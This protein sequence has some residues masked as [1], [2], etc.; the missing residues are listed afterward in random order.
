MSGL[1]S[2]AGPGLDPRF[3]SGEGVSVFRQNGRVQISR[4]TRFRFGEFATAYAVLRDI[5][6]VFTGEDFEPVPNY[7]GLESGMRRSLVAAY[8]AGID[9]SDPAQLGRLIRVF[10]DAI[11]SWGR[12]DQGEFVQSAKEMIR[13]LQ[14]DGVPLDDA[15]ELTTS[16]AALNVPLS[17]FNRLGEP[18]VVQQHLERISA[19]VERDPPAAVGSCKKLVE[20]VCKF[21]LQDYGVE[22]SR[23]D[24]LLDLYKKT[25]KELKL[26]RESVPGSAKFAISPDGLRLLSGS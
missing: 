11:D 26:S 10:V 13:S 23:K 19:N 4:R 8:F 16:V 14:R 25:A 18:R 24:D 3:P 20:S 22:F 17:D 5:E 1:V 12:D 2:T 7:E 15:G 6:S 21:I 9:L